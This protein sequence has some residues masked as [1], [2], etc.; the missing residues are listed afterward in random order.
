MTITE[1]QLQAAMRAYSSEGWQGMRAGVRAALAALAAAEQSRE[2]V[3]DVSDLT[4]ELWALAQLMPGEGIEDGARRIEDRLSAAA[5]Q[6]RELFDHFAGITKMVDSPAPA[7]PAKKYPDDG[8]Q[9]DGDF[10]AE[11]TMWHWMLKCP[12][13]IQ[14]HTLDRLAKHLGGPAPTLPP[15]PSEEAKDEAYEKAPPEVARTDVTVM[16]RAAYAIDAKAPDAALHVAVDHGIPNGGRSVEI[17]MS[18]EPRKFALGQRVRKIKGA[19]WQGP[20]VGYYSTALT[21]IGYAVE[22]EAHAGSVQIY[23]EVALE[24]ARAALNGE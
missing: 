12:P 17:L 11:N 16:L 4:H 8:L 5:E 19:Y 3:G 1:K 21:P 18:S 6:S 7:A 15:E 20:I 24:L 2:P 13:E 14:R 9:F 10:A 23:P 22:S